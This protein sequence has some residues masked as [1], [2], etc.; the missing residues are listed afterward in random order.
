[1]PGDVAFRSPQF[2]RIPDV[3]QIAEYIYIVI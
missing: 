2:L 1:M 3:A